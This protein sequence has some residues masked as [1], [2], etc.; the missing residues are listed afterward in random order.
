M[1]YN[2]INPCIS[3]LFSYL[4]TDLKVQVFSIEPEFGRHAN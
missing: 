2:C 3:G 1:T 4:A